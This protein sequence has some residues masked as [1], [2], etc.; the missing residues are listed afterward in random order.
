MITK[1]QLFLFALL[2]ARSEL[3]Y[4]AFTVDKNR[5]KLTIHLLQK[6]LTAMVTW[7]LGFCHPLVK[8]W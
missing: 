6:I 3:F 1:Q 4:G 5:H 7:H 8:V 2:M